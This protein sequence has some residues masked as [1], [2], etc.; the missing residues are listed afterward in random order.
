MKKIA[1][2][3]LLIVVGCNMSDDIEQLGDG[4]WLSIEG[5]GNN[6]IFSGEAYGKGIHADVIE[7]DYSDDYIVAK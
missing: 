1:L 7:Y 3:S 6:R 4:Y 2:L 5:R